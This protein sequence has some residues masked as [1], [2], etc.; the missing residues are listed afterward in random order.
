MYTYTLKYNDDNIPVILPVLVRACGIA[1]NFPGGRK[2]KQCMYN[3]TVTLTPA[4]KQRSNIYECNNNLFIIYAG[5]ILYGSRA[6][7]GIE[8]RYPYC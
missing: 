6:R 5:I 1:V 4:Y 2:K 8:C 3:N 7:R